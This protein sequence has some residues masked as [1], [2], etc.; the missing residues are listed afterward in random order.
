VVVPG[1]SHSR[2]VLTLSRDDKTAGPAILNF[3]RSHTVVE[4][5]GERDNMATARIAGIPIR[6]T[7][8]HFPKGTG[9]PSR[10]LDLQSHIRRTRAHWARRNRRH[11][12]VARSK[13]SP[14]VRA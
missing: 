2:I 11:W 14:V 8:T 13:E 3:V 10:R 4:K 12:E 6:S 1:E 9:F 7:A 5:V